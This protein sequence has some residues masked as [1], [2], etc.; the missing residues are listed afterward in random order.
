MTWASRGNL[1]ELF[2]PLAGALGVSGG[3]S[4]DPWASL[5]GPW[6]LPGR[7]G[8]GPGCIGRV[9]GGPWGRGTSFVLFDKGS[10]DGIGDLWGFWG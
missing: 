9:P 8:G 7:I 1:W 3:S 6:E 10:L 5:G 4:G 2:W